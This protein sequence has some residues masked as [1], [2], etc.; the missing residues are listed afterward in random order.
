MMQ[1]ESAYVI[2]P[3]RAGILSGRTDR[4]NANRPAQFIRFSRGRQL[5]KAVVN[6][7]GLTV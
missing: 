5:S 6:G 3:N 2:N 7:F 1:I 4:W